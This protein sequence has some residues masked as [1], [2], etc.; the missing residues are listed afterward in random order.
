SQTTPTHANLRGITLAPDGQIYV[1]GNEGTVLTSTGDGALYAGG[2]MGQIHRYNGTAWELVFDLYLDV[3]ILDMCGSR[4]DCIY[5][6]G[7]FGL[8]LRWNGE[9]WAEFHAGTDNFLFDVWGDALDNIFIVGLSG[10]LVHFDGSAGTDR[11]STRLNS[12][13]VKS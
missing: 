4:P 10:T 8:V 11:K 2:T 1:V 5:A 6:V 7:D 3:T 12:S 13:H 9:S